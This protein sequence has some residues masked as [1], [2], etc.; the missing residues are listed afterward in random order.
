MRK[1]GCLIP[2]VCLLLL[3]SSCAGVA[4]FATVK[5]GESEKFSKAEIKEAVQVVRKSAFSGT[6]V[7]NIVYDEARSDEVIRSYMENGKGSVNGVSEENVIVLFTDFL[8]GGKTG[9][10]NP[11]DVYTDYSWTLIRDGKD[12]AWIVDDCGYG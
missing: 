12:G 8:T 2:V 7:A 9:A 3:L 5:I 6:L 11:Y 1:I 4:R 10:L